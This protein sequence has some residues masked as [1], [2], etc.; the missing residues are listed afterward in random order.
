MMKIAGL[1]LNFQASLNH[2]RDLCLPHCYRK[3][4]ESELSG[5]EVM[6]NDVKME[7]MLIP[8]IEKAYVHEKIQ[9]T[10]H[11]IS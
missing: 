3:F 2:S 7:E 10:Q 8:I 4:I 5:T 1:K 6:L 9:L 11:F